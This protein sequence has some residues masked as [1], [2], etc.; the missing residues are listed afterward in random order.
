[1][2]ARRSGALAVVSVGAGVLLV[3]LLITWAATIG[4]SEVL[5]GGD[6]RSDR[7]PLTSGSDTSSASYDPGRL[8]DPPHEPNNAALLHV[9]AV[10]L[11]LVLLVRVLRWAGHARR[12]RRVRLARQRSLGGAEFAVIE[13]SAALAHELLADAETQRDVLVDGTP[14][15]AVVACWHRFETSAAAAGMERRDW[16]TSAEFT[17][18]VLDLVEADTAAVVR[19]SGLYRE[20]RF[21]EH[22]ITETARAEALTALDEIHRTIRRAAEV[23]A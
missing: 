13:T 16:E 3:V 8:S 6:D 10:V 11:A 14:R 21:S 9:V 2:T 20:A 23:S 15:N 18:R 22:E 17:I 4:P 12:A 19:L 1:M 5:Q 7:L